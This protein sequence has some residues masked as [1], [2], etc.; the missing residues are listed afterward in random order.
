[1][2]VDLHDM[3]GMFFE[4]F[5]IRL[6][7]INVDAEDASAVLKARKKA[8][9]VSQLRVLEERMSELTP[10]EIRLVRQALDRTPLRSKDG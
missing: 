9:H 1:M 2:C 10:K 3:F 8:R 7:S 5:K 6:F 4:E